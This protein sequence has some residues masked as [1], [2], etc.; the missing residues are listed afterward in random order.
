V[1]AMFM[2]VRRSA[3]SSVGAANVE[4]IGFVHRISPCVCEQ[5]GSYLTPIFI[6]GNSGYT[7]LGEAPFYYF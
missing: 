2:D 1:N 5:S 6:S 3:R 4:R 7:P